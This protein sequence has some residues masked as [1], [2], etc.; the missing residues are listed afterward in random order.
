MDNW[1]RDRWDW[2][3]A[4]RKSRDLSDA[5]KVLAAAFCDDLSD[6]DSPCCSHTIE[7]IALD[8]GKSERSVQR[9]IRELEAGGWIEVHRARGKSRKSEFRCKMPATLAT[10]TGRPRVTNLSSYARPKD[11][12][13]VTTVT[14]KGDNRVTP[15]NKEPKSHQSARASDAPDPI[16]IRY[17][18]HRFLGSITHGPR[19]VPS[20]D[21][22]SLNRWAAWLAD[23][24]L[25][26]LCNTPL[27]RKAKKGDTVFFA[28]PTKAPPTCA[29]GRAEARAFFAA[30]LDGEASRHAAQ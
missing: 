30:V 20:T 23:E 21:F 8:V 22:G 12:P 5:A 11:E 4:L 26:K 24:G 16:P 10:E 18:D 13:A 19:I 7:D 2:K 9:A 3:R 6:R 1:N 25:P 27:G 15:Y 17:R 14:P 28:L 29:A